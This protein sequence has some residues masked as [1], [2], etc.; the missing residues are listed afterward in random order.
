MRVRRQGGLYVRAIVF[1]MTDALVSTVGLL[2]GVSTAG[3][4]HS[5]VVVTGVVYAI[6]EAFSMAMGNYLA[7]ETG[8]EYD[9]GR[10]VKGMKPLLV[11]LVMFVTSALVALI[12]IA[13]YILLDGPVAL[14]VSVALSV[15]AL[16]VAGALGARAAGVSMLSHGVRM[17]ALGGAA[18][19]IG[20]VVGYYYPENMG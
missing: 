11:A 13:P 20:I 19:L 2:A 10:E 12:P 14:V 5:L 6:V 15:V 17:A 1:G 18:I 7:E 9:A 4:S 8:E 16:F 3:A